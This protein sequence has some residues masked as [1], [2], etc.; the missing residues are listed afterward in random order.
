MPSMS[1]FRIFTIHYLVEA[2]AACI[3][4]YN[5]NI[6]NPITFSVIES[7]KKT[8]VWEAVIRHWSLV[9][10]ILSFGS[11]VLCGWCNYHT[12]L[13]HSIYGNQ[14]GDW[15]NNSV[16]IG[17]GRGQATGDEYRLHSF[18][19]SLVKNQVHECD[20]ALVDFPHFVER[21]NCDM[22]PNSTASLTDIRTVYS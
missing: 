6:S 22:I 16:W 18:F 7:F 19:L 8:Q 11:N 1:R 14:R 17:I 3:E 21:P 2:L 9:Q 4:E 10:N 5:K 12:H 13:L 15:R 20:K